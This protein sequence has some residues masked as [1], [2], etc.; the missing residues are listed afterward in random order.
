LTNAAGRLSES[1]MTNRVNISWGRILAE[2]SAILVSILLA[3]GIQAWWEERQERAEEAE[4]LSR[5]HAEFS[6]NLARI[7]ERT[8][9][10][11]VLRQGEELFAQIKEARKQGREAILVTGFT[12]RWFAYAP[13]FEADTPILDGLISRGQLE[14][15][16]DRNVQSVLATWERE[17]RDY[18]AFAERARRYADESLLPALYRRGDVGD[19]LMISMSVA[20]SDNADLQVPVQIR[21]DDELKGIVAGRYAAG[22]SAQGKFE[23]LRSA[24]VDVIGSIEPH[25]P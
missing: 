15:I 19:I 9:Y 21:V 17:L 16:E 18:T 24:A 6:T 4:L 3:F 1:N 20:M 7:D 13:T 25:L 23:V 11:A 14:I 10:G 2:G 5:L 8:Y 12:L 22:R